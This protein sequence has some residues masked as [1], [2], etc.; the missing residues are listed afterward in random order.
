M[1]IYMFFS[2]NACVAAFLSQLLRKPCC[3][4]VDE[5]LT[6]DRLR[7]KVWLGQ[8]NQIFGHDPA[9]ERVD[10]GLFQRLAKLHKLR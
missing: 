1:N 7:F 10:A 9:V 6:G 3:N 2:H 5:F 8:A 4:G